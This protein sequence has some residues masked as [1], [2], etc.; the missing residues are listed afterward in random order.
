MQ[1][2]WISQ[3]KANEF[4]LQH[5]R[6]HGKI[7]GAII[8][9]AAYKNGEIV[10]VATIGR[11]SARKINS[12]EVCEVTRLGTFGTKNACTKLYGACARMAKDM[13]FL[14]IISYTGKDEEG[15]SLKAAGWFLEDD[16]CGGTEWNGR[17]RTIQTLFGEVEKYP[18]TKKKRWAKILN[19][20]KQNFDARNEFMRIVEEGYKNLG[21]EFA[22]D[23]KELK[24][25]RS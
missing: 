15:T 13:G 8:C 5:H 21:I 2:K 7:V 12:Q 19:V 23:E 17:E 9:L 22:K 14:K 16:D 4:I 24:T 1:T 10:G 20:Q 11:P 3:R 18:F 6:H 25:L